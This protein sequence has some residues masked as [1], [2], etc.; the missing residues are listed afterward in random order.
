MNAMPWGR[1]VWVLRALGRNPLVRRHDRMEALVALLG[2]IVVTL[3]IPVVIHLGRDYFARSLERIDH[4]TRTLHMV[5]AT[6]VDAK[7]GTPDRNPAAT[8]IVQ[9]Q[10]K[11][12][13]EDRVE[14]VQAPSKATVGDRVPVWLD[15]RGAV[16]RPPQTRADAQGYATAYG[17][18]LWWTT[19]AV[20]F[21]VAALTRVSLDRRRFDAWDYEWKLVSARGGGW[22]NSGRTE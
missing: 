13:F 14:T 2:V 19:A 1:H 11:A 16:T 12:G 10:W 15:H 18:G 22:A 3:A 5:D 7:P 17:L 9:A 4:Q 6:V 8:R 20:C 21:T